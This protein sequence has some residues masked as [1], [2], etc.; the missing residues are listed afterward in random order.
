MSFSFFSPKY[1]HKDKSSIVTVEPAQHYLEYRQ[2]LEKIDDYILVGDKS[3]GNSSAGG[4]YKPKDQ[5]RSME[6]YLI[7]NTRTRTT[8]NNFLSSILYKQL[9]GFQAC[10]DSILVDKDKLIINSLFLENFE[11]I[12]HIASMNLDSKMIAHIDRTNLPSIIKY[13][14]TQENVQG[15]EEVMAASLFLCEVDINGGNIGVITAKEGNKFFAKID[16]EGSGAMDSFNIPESRLCNIYL[17]KYGESLILSD[18]MISACEKVAKMNLQSL[19]YAVEYAIDKIEQAIKKIPD[20]DLVVEDLVRVSRS[21]NIK[22]SII[23]ELYS[24]LKMTIRYS[25]ISYH[26][27][28][29]IDTEIKKSDEEQQKFKIIKAYF[30]KVDINHVLLSIYKKNLFSLLKTRKKHMQELANII[31][32]KMTVA[33]HDY[34]QF[35]MILENNPGFMDDI[36]RVRDF[37]YFITCNI[38]T[39]SVKDWLDKIDICAKRSESKKV[40]SEIKDK[41]ISKKNV[42]DIHAEINAAMNKQ[43]RSN[44]RFMLFSIGIE[45][46]TLMKEIKQITVSYFSK[47]IT[48]RY[49][50]HIEQIC[51]GLFENSQPD[52][53]AIIEFSAQTAAILMQMSAAENDFNSNAVRDF[54]Y[55]KK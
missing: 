50:N 10:E 15:F 52:R 6:R 38:S 7:K 46:Q 33:N 2:K 49:Q 17:P 28:R 35:E 9:L 24:A 30:N 18:K 8:I 45:K 51:D 48:A 36:Y 11:T 40:V 31:R 14:K 29:I 44:E 34:D 37:K 54:H 3:G 26:V 47:A 25:K 1:F 16:H 5:K 23:Q 53:S 41:I 21:D 20:A 12:S 32:L 27:R 19:Y 13:L 43:L 4:I 42:M 55:K 39:P 22:K